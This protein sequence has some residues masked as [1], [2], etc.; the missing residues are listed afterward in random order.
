MPFQNKALE[1]QGLFANPDHVITATATENA[2]FLLKYKDLIK[3]KMTDKKTKTG[4]KIIIS[5]IAPEYIQHQKSARW[6]MIAGTAL[7]LF[8]VWAIYTKSWSMALAIIVFSLVY[9]YTQS[10]HPPKDIKIAV[11]ESGIG[12]GKMFFPYSH[13]QAFWIIN[14]P[15]LKTLNLRV[16]K[17][18]FSDVI[19]QLNNQDPVVL[20]QYLVGQV[21]EWEGKDER[22]GDVFLRL[23]KL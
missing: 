20:R 21:A 9:Q 14:K 3:Q 1:S 7:L 18:F 8:L 13:I 11:T 6:Y 12:V 15:G 10:N 17:S 19:I 22:L 23:L 5:W 2:V 4:D 16:S